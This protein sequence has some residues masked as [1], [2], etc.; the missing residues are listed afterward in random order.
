MRE[1]VFIFAR[2]AIALVFAWIAIR[3]LVGEFGALSIEEVTA[4]LSRI[5]WGAAGLMLLATAVVYAAVATYDAFAL[6]YGG[7]AL[8]LRRSMVTS[9]SS[10]AIS[11]V[12]GFPVFTGNAVRFWFYESWGLGAKETALAAIV[13]TV[14]CN[15]ALA[16]IA[17]VSL[18]A[19]PGSIEMTGLDGSWGWPVGVALLAVSLALILFAMFGQREIRIWKLHVQRPG[20]I[21]LPHL[22]VCAVDYLATATVLYIPLGHTLGMDFLSFVVLFS[23]AKTIGIVSNVPGGLGVFEAI[24]ASTT[25][26]VPAA[27]LVAALIAYRAIFYLAPFGI[28]AVAV[29]VHG[30]ARTSRRTAP[31]QSSTPSD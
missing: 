18:V 10:Y 16:I 1:K 8:S 22:A 13:T 12:L 14:A 27:D 17:G 23:I 9:T 11:N 6:R 15:H 7:V 25:S 20:S 2:I 21:L 26:N 31:R 19:A 3:V 24:M 28:A 5:G 29:A 30:L 4:S